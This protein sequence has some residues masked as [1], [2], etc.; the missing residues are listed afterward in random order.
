MRRPLFY[1]CEI[2]DMEIGFRVRNMG[3]PV[4]WAVV[5]QAPAR[6]S[7]IYKDSKKVCIRRYLRIK[8]VIGT[9]QIICWI[10]ADKIS[11]YFNYLYLIDADLILYTPEDICTR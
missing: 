6:L 2:E 5:A 3:G 1:R 8:F 7:I 4:Y 10:S 9:K 11:R